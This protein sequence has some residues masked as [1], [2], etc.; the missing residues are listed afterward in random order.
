MTE[1]IEPRRRR[2]DAVKENPMVIRLKHSVHPEYVRDSS[3]EGPIW[4]MHGSHFCSGA[5]IQGDPFFSQGIPPAWLLWYRL[6]GCIY[7]HTVTRTHVPAVE[8]EADLF[9]RTETSWCNQLQYGWSKHLSR[10]YTCFWNSF[11]E[12]H[13][14][15][16]CYISAPQLF[17]C[18]RYIRF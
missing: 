18:Y 16:F 10:C 5:L 8:R 7:I 11:L 2:Y 9:Y 17:G 1:K 15:F 13:F 12:L 3:T 4:V 14:P 6:D